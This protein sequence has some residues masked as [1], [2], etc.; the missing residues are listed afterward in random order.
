V[1]AGSVSTHRGHCIYVNVGVR[2]KGLNDMTLIIGTA[3]K[4][5]TGKVQNG[6]AFALHASLKRASGEQNLNTK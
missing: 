4:P 1:H 3:L 2:Y 6:A 5:F